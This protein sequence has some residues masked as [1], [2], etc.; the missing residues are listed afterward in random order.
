M[1]RII[2]IALFCFS[3]LTVHAQDTIFLK[4]DV[5]RYEDKIVLRWNTTSLSCFLNYQ[6]SD[7]VIEQHINNQWQTMSILAPK[8]VVEPK[9]KSGNERLM[10]TMFISEQLKKMQSSLSVDPINQMQQAD[11]MKALWMT[12]SLNADIDTNSANFARL[13]YTI[14]IDKNIDQE[15]LYRV[16]AK[17]NFAISDTV[18]FIPSK[19]VFK[20]TDQPLLF[21]DE[22]EQVIELKWSA[23]R[24]Y[25][26]YVVERSAMDGQF[27][28]INK[29]PL[30]IPSEIG[31]NGNM[32]FKD[33]VKNYTKYQYRIYGID[34]FG[35]VSQNSLVVVAMGRDKTPPLPVSGL[36][37]AETNSKQLL[38][39]WDGFKSGAD[40]KGIAVAL[41]NKSEENYVPLTQKI[42]PWSTQNYSISVDANQTDY[43]VMVE[44]FDSVGNGSTSEIFYQLN[45]NTAPT[46]PNGVAAVVDSKGIVT[47]KWRANKERDL[48]GYLVYR[49][50]S[51]KAEFGG[52]IN[53]PIK[54]T[55]VLDTLSLKL[56]N[57]DVFY[58]VVSVDHRLNRSENSETVKVQRP[59]TLPPVAPLLVTYVIKLDHFNLKF[60]NSSS[61][62]VTQHILYK[63]KEGDKQYSK[64]ILNASDT[65]YIDKDI[66]ENTN[67]TYY[68]QAVD[69]AGNVSPRSE[70]VQIKT[71]K[72]Y[73]KQAVKVFSVQYDSATAG[74]KIAWNYNMTSV[75]KVVI[76]RGATPSDMSKLP[77][78]I[79][80]TSNSFID[81]HPLKGESYYALKLYFIDGTETL[82]SIPLGV[83]YN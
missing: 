75:S 6:N 36:T 76:Y 22:R 28:K 8:A 25:T 61:L 34:M 42:L 2:V 48:N 67:Y 12:L 11:D 35:D 49:S 66:V 47:L 82:V 38:V 73:F 81:Q 18:Y 3:T 37:I 33:S 20:S 40:V 19:S 4:G 50:S 71:L 16:Y 52:I 14:G 78:K 74:V 55:F 10:T 83:K 70:V 46:K 53:V 43:Y 30:V 62:D 77:N 58:R 44:V 64:I 51:E 7:V 1:R 80:T 54:D 69:E 27:K 59:D 21:A 72:N 29:A 56:L 60:F 41:K 79:P 9:N 5:R 23:N 13:R 45:D 65:E 39:K 57:R 26:S 15:Q 68:L 63:L 32:Y 31:D 24:K 17:T